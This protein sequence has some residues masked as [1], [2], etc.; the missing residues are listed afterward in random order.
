MLNGILAD[1]FAFTRNLSRIEDRISAANR[2]I[3]SGIRVNQASDDPSAITTIIHTQSEI[4]RITQVQTNLKSASKDAALA[5]TALQTAA[6]LLDQLTTLGSQATG[7]LQT[8]A[9]RANIGSQ[10]QQIEQQLVG[11]ANTQFEGK[12]I[13]G[14]DDTATPPYAYNWTATSGVVVNSTAA[15]TIIVR[16]SN[17]NAINPKLT[18]QQIFDLGSSGTPA[19]GNIFNTVFQLGQ[20]LLN[21]DVPGIQAATVSIKDAVDHLGKVTTTYGNVESWLQK[22]SDYATQQLADLQTTLSS[23]RDADLPA[24]ITSLTTNEAALD[25]SLSAHATL[26]A[27]S[28]FSYLG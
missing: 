6:N 10:V 14:G 25:A 2:Q 23:V 26:S 15:S 8:A 22:A 3:S 7:L 5:D 11:L 27:K 12:Y 20:A 1:D 13:F 17:G 28:L 16:D 9:T 19:P 21:N 4:D 24:A 18:A